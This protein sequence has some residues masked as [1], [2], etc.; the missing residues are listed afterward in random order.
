MVEN[1]AAKGA[2]WSGIVIESE[3]KLLSGRELRSKSGLAKGGLG[4]TPFEVGVCPRGSWERP[5]Q[6][7]LEGQ[8]SGPCRCG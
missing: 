8:G 6:Y 1:H 7:P 3:I 2:N 4:L 5:S